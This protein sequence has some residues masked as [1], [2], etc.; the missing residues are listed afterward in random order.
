[1]VVLRLSNRAD[2]YVCASIR[3]KGHLQDLNTLQNIWVFVAHSCH[4]KRKKECSEWK[5]VEIM[6]PSVS[7]DWL[8]R[9]FGL[10]YYLDFRWGSPCQKHGPHLDYGRN[11]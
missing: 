9:L 7:F 11:I 10:C 2:V 8:S 4:N 6:T 5:D 1:M 3:G